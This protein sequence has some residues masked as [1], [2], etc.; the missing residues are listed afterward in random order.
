VKGA[1]DS[2]LYWR[3]LKSAVF[4]KDEDAYGAKADPLE[5]RP[6]SSARAPGTAPGPYGGHE[7]RDSEDWYKYPCGNAMT[8]SLPQSPHEPG[9][10]HTHPMSHRGG[11]ESKMQ[12]GSTPDI[13]SSEQ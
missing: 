8:R 6:R 10:Q 4:V 9:S 1:V 5:E 12:S 2:G 3:E 13:T 7:Y 11:N